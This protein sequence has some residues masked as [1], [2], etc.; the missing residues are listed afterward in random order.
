MKINI[1]I[2]LLLGLFCFEA[3]GQIHNG[4]DIIRG[5]GDPNGIATLDVLNEY[6]EGILYRDT[7]AKVTYE[8]RGAGNS[9]EWATLINSEN[10]A[11]NVGGGDGVLTDVTATKTGNNVSTVYTI[12]TDGSTST[13]TEAVSIADAD[14]SITNELQDFVLANAT[15]PILRIN[16]TNSGVQFVAGDNVSIDRLT[17]DSLITFSVPNIDDAD[18]SPTNENVT[19]LQPAAG[20]LQLV[21]ENG[22]TVNSPL[23]PIIQAGTVELPTYTTFAAANAALNLGEAWKCGAGSTE[24]PFGSIQYATE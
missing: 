16:R 5:T 2:A 13:I 4:G 6:R 19:Q 23:A 12:T 1:I 7:V 22:N 17:A 3:T 15:N 14:A 21:Q 10:I 18:A 11:A 9:P 24:C 20:N 8:Y